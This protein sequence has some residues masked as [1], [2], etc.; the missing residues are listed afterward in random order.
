MRGETEL[1]AKI[2]ELRNIKPREEWVFLTKKRIFREVNVRDFSRS[3][4]WDIFEALFRYKYA[5][6]SLVAVFLLGSIFVSA[7]QSLPGDLFYPIKKITER[8]R[9]AIVPERDQPTLQL[10]Y[11]NQQL[12]N[13]V[14]VAEKKKIEKLAPL[15]EEYQANVSEAAK[16]LKKI[17]KP[18]VKKIVEKTKELEENKE[19]AES[20][21]I[22]V[23]EPKELKNALAEVVKNEIKDLENQSLSFDQEKILKEIK[24]DYN[25][26]EY[27]KALEKILILSYPQEK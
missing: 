7:Q 11:A 4:K 23:E 21:G 6:V 8:A 15:I 1:I 27:S 22:V 2:K 5:T 16:I 18:D 9:L 25:K 17:E 3:K 12:E 26:E 19:K 20:L 13:L 10:E 14:E 24:D